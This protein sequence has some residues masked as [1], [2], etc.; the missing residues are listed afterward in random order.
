GYHRPRS[1]YSRGLRILA[2]RRR[3]RSHSLSLQPFL[4]E[5]EV[6]VV[7]SGIG[8]LTT[9][10]L[11]ASRGVEVCLFER[12]SVVG[13]C[14]ANVEHLGYSFEPTAGLYSGWESGGIWE[15]IFS[16]L[17]TP[18]PQIRQLSPSYVVRLPDG[19]DVSVS[20][21]RE[22]FE[23]ALARTF[24]DCANAAI[25][26]YHQLAQIDPNRAGDNEVVAN[27]LAGVSQE[28]RLFVDVQLQTLAQRTSADCTIADAA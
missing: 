4:M 26:F 15:R 27:R 3:A 23:E 8:G 24:P 6:I 2:A 5:C 28:F 19:R 7:G 14:V 13:G 11:L 18:P 9:A 12:Q 25:D 1:I 17:K 16:E 10:A 21:D 22:H 20:H